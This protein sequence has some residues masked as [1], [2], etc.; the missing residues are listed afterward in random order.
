MRTCTRSSPR[1]RSASR[2]RRSSRSSA[3]GSRRCPTAWP[4]ACRRS[5]SSQQLGISPE[6][7]REQMDAYFA[8]FGG[9][10]DYLTGVVDA[11]P[12]GRLHRD[13]PRPPPL[14]SGPHQRQR[15]AAA[16]GRADGAQRADPGLR[17]RHHQGRDARRPARAARRAGCRRGCCCRS[18]TSSS[19][20]SRRASAT[21]SRRSSDAR[22]ARRTARAS[23]STSP[24][25]PAAP[26]TT[27]PTDAP[28]RQPDAGF[29]VTKMAVPGI[30]WPRSGL[31]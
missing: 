18:T 9:V 29:S 4:T 8:R 28:R 30:T 11:G 14:P 7:A 31:H 21:R 5:V 23:R 13:D 15:A 25:A 26:G 3:G 2:S 19:S 27:P 22:W 24:W 6:E 12:D 1:S 10:R 16:D 17:R 20:R